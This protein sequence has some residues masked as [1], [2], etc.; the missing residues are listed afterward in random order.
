MRNATQDDTP[1]WLEAGAAHC[2]FCFMAFHEEA[3]YFCIECDRPV[4][5]ACVVEVHE[6]REVLCPECAEE[7]SAPSR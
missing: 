2:E 1:W 6:T 5:P 7:H 3:A 4:C